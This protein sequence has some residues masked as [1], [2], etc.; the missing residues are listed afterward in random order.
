MYEIFSKLL[1]SQNLKAA[2]VCRGTGLPSS[3]F[4]E[5]KKGKSTPKQD[6]LDL[7][8]NF[9]KVDTRIFKS[10]EYHGLCFDCGMHYI[11]SDKKSIAQHEQHHRA[12]EKAVK[13]FGFCW[14]YN[15]RE[16][17]KAI[18]RNKLA[19]GNLSIDER[20]EANIE[21]F[22]A[23]FSRSLEANEYDFRHVDFNQY[24]PM[25]LYQE[26]FKKL[27]DKE[28]YDVLVKKYGTSKGIKEG[29]T[30]Y[31]IPEDNESHNIAAHKDDN[32]NWTP[33]EIKKIEEYKQLLLAAR[34][35]KK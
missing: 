1:E 8:A 2:D 26:Q 6:K 17:A 10:S 23:L 7:I 34:N 21:V 9:F 33:D 27:I 25:L 12:W 31:Y 3:L 14:T 5:W 15:V 30:Y 11:S 13:K 22:K 19:K 32:E 4:S 18:A 24:V 20:V 29:E 16:N 28:V 35:N